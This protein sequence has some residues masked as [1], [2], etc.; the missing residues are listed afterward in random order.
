MEKL[1]ILK[2][3][4]SIHCFYSLTH[5]HSFNG[6]CCLPTGGSIFL[7]L[8]PVPSFRNPGSGPPSRD[9]N[10]GQDEE[11]PEFLQAPGP[12]ETIY[13]YPL[14]MGTWLFFFFP[15]ANFQ[16]RI[17]VRCLKSHVSSGIQQIQT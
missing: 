1:C 5:S 9:T 11:L 8:L 14:L 13:F 6:D 17:L 10:D 12:L 15:V 2:L 3:G 4:E 16:F 7:T